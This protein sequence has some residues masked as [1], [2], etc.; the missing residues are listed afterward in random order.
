MRNM[1]HLTGT[2]VFAVISGWFIIM[3]S[4]QV[5][6]LCTYSLTAPHPMRRKIGN[7]VVYGLITVVIGG[8]GAYLLSRGGEV[9][10]VLDYF[11][12]PLIDFVPLVGWVNAYMMGIITGDPGKSLMF[13][14]LLVFFP[15]LG[16]ALVRRTE[17][18]YYEDVLQATERTYVTK[19]AIKDGKMGAKNLNEN[20]RAGKSGITGKG[21][22]ASIFFYRHLTEQRRTG[23]FILDKGSI[24][25]IAGAAIG[26]FVLRNL[27]QKGEFTP[28]ISALAA[29]CILA[30]I[31]YF[32]TVSGKFTQELARPF[33]YL[34]PA[35]EILKLFYSNLASVLKSFVEG[36]IAFTIITILAGLPWWYIPMATL[37]YASLSQLY[38][39]M[40][41]MTQRI[42]GDSNSKI[43][44]TILYLF[45]ASVL[46]VP[47]AA[48]FGILQ[49][50]FYFAGQ[51][52]LFIAYLAATIYNVGVSIL[53]LWLGKGILREVNL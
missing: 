39:S 26:G 23:M 4:S 27:T 47:G 8:L 46:I 7:Y 36:L 30:Y 50:V 17:S 43:L 15:V 51:Q 1:L 33:I 52:F 3:L 24:L 49:A 19:Q 32:L 14:L 29:F 31:L 21:Q 20:V 16:I 34:V 18:D 2:G 37:A 12:L 40:S 38:I 9:E 42:L 11:G 44:S 41:I 25:I 35:P 45:S 28:F 5:V 10:S 48:I 13:L 53:V 6:S 22:G